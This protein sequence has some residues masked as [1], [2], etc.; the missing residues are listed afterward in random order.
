MTRH[1]FA[2]NL[3]LA[4]LLLAIGGA[5]ICAVPSSQVPTL[6][7]ITADVEISAEGKASVL[8]LK[9]VSAPLHAAL[10]AQVQQM[11]F[12]PAR[13]DERA[14]ES[15]TQLTM[16]VA[17]EPVSDAKYG[18][19]VKD[20]RLGPTA[21]RTAPPAY[22]GKLARAGKGGAVL[23]AFALGADGRPTDIRAIASSGPEWVKAATAAM[24]K[25]RFEPQLI[26]GTPVTI[27]MVQPFWFR[28]EHDMEPPAF[29]CPWDSARPSAP[30]QSQCEDRIEII[31]YQTWGT[32]VRSP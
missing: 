15:T 4:V 3:A 6:L 2:N 24:R 1:G 10:V 29:E 31:L 22:P 26:E 9:G 11:R 12:T 25:W 7:R 17:L 14:V 8:L 32:T 21:R 28:S 20:V 18:I 30:G 13:V 23:L 19:V 5:G 16:Q 27:E